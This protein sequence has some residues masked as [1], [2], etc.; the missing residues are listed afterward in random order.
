MKDIH[1]HYNSTK[2]KKKE[3]WTYEILDLCSVLVI[4]CPDCYLHSWFYS[5]D[6]GDELSGHVNI[7]CVP[8]GAC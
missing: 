8:Y 6:W 3:W 4:G 7:T 1:Y 5:K 2:Q